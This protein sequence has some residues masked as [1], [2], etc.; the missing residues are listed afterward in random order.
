[1]EWIDNNLT[2]EAMELGYMLNFSYL[3][4]RQF[5]SLLSEQRLHIKIH[6]VAEWLEQHAN[7]CDVPKSF[8]LNPMYIY[9]RFAYGEKVCKSGMP[10]YVD[11]NYF[12]VYNRLAFKH[13]T[14]ESDAIWFQ[15]WYEIPRELI[16][17]FTQAPL[18]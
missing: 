1:M 15:W 9:G 3:N 13:F 11:A 5:I 2:K 8:S 6:P 7:A 12:L 18:F 17:P 14:E 4:P 10:L 16:L